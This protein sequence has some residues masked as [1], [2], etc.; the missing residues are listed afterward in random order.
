[1]STMAQAMHIGAR[2]Y[3]IFIAFRRLDFFA[4]LLHRA[5]LSKRCSM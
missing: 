4:G 1:M 3:Q 5:E 2:E